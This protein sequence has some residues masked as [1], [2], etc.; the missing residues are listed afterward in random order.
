MLLLN[1]A[2]DLIPPPG[3]SRRLPARRGGTPLIPAPLPLTWRL[4]LASALEQY[5]PGRLYAQ[6]RRGT[7]QARLQTGR[8]QDHET[9]DA[10]RQRAAARSQARF[11]PAPG[12][13]AW[14]PLVHSRNGGPGARRLKTRVVSPVRNESVFLIDGPRRS[15]GDFLIAQKVT[16][17]AGRNIPS[18]AKK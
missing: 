5:A 11:L 18:P 3:F 6:P 10:E 15:F 9:W 7:G 17:P 16:R 8:T 12:S 13:T 14:P 2:G 1:G 4:W